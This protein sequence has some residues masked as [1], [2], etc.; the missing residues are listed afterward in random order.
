MRLTEL[1]VHPL[2]SGATRPVPSAEVLRRGLAD[3]R[4][5]MVVDGDGVLV[6]AREESRLL[7][8]AADTPRT[9]PE[10][11]SALR[12]RAPG[13]PDLDEGLPTGREVG[14]RLH[15]HDLRAVEASAQAHDWLRSAVGRDD[16]RLVWC[17]D[18]ASRGLNP[19]FSEPGDHTAFADGYPVTIASE[20][21]LERLNGWIAEA[22][23][24]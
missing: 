18:P 3:D 15:R 20:S 10:V 14:V 7:T 13:V 12:L 16:L 21:S 5:W 22:T 19:L 17:H 11:S 24:A 9:S 4:S 1:N 8:I 23:A 2:K 6:S